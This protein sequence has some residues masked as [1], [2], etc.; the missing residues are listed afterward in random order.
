VVVVAVD[1][2]VALMLAVTP[3]IQFSSKRCSP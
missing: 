1:V 2:V 3:A